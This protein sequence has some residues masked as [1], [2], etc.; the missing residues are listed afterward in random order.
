MALIIVK[1]EVET[2]IKVETLDDMSAK[3]YVYLKK[4]LGWADARHVWMEGQRISDLIERQLFY[5][6]AV[7]E[8]ERRLPE[9]EMQVSGLD[10]FEKYLHKPVGIEEF[11][12]S[13]EY[14]DKKADIYPAVMEELLELN[15]GD[16]TE[17]VLTGGIGSAKTT[18]ALYT[19]AYQVYLL[20]CMRSPHR[21]F[22]LDPSSEILLIFQSIN[23]A[24]A[25]NVDFARFK[26][27]IGESRYFKEK[28][29]FKKDVESRL[30]FPNRIEVV[31]VSGQETAAIG[32]NV[33]GGLI[34]ELNYMAVIEKSKQS[35]DKGTFDQA[36]SLYNSIARRRKSRFLESGKLPG[37]LC[38]VSSKKY[39]GQFTDKKMEEREREI[40]EAG[41]STIYLY[42]KRVWDIKPEGTFT[43]GW[44][45]VFIGDESRKPRILTENEE[46]PEDDRELCMAVPKEF[47]ND[48]VDD[49]TNALRE[50]AGVSTLARH[51]YFVE[52]ERVNASF[53]KVASIFSDEWT[54]F[55]S[56]K[57]SIRKNAF[58]NPKLPRF[59]HVDLAKSGDSAGVAIGCVYDFVD[60][61]TIDR[62]ESGYMPKIRFDGILEV[63]P[64]KGA[65]ILF[66]KIRQ[67]F[68]VLR[69][70]GMNVR[71]VTFDSFESTD[72]QQILRQQAFV[73]GDQ[74]MDILP[75]KPYDFLKSAIY[76]GRVI[77]QAHPHVKKELLHLER[78]AKTG[79]IDHPPAGSKDCAD[80]MAG[81]VFGL[82]MRREI[83]GNFGIPLV[84][85]PSSIN[86]ST[87]KLA[88]KNDKLKQNMEIQE[89]VDLNSP[90]AITRRV[91]AGRSM[92]NG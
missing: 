20:S 28:Y 40:R 50:I 5:A 58:W 91:S 72:S 62:G 57:L 84:M 76:D 75:C 22:G 67:I 79:K 12:C 34:D 83:W 2:E 29:P 59:A 24:L 7:Q 52:V 61:K 71:W 37:I 10:E 68:L 4:Y 3:V 27:M 55:V 66:F 89:A 80:A 43:K 45:H 78:D 65:E 49:I 36:T 33:I 63:R 41:R 82:T 21:E 25:K 90:E 53:G 18:I 48:F 92:T 85:V 16:Y 60:L 15:S 64:P 77:A 88:E 1:P 74:S 51:P 86:V 30:K 19:N 42:D 6:H 9:T 13:R 87:D 32:Q 8:I 70:M 17:A 26:S 46:M 31:P 39:P 23:A 54:D 14:L 81:V 35:V 38:L 47:E 56:N 73:T 11:L 69:K 44:F